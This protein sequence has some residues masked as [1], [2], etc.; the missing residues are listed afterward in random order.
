MQFDG[1]E[2]QNKKKPQNLV[3]EELRYEFLNSYDWNPE[4]CHGKN[5][6]V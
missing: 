6:G 4:I 1:V 2:K 5:F 3:G